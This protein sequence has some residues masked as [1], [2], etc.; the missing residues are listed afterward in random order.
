MNLQKWTQLSEMAAAL[1]VVVT[2]VILIQEVRTNTLAIRQQGLDQR[3]TN[4]AQ[5]FLDPAVL[6]RLYA[7][8]KSVDGGVDPDVAAFMARYDMSMEEALQWTRHLSMLWRGVESEF[9]ING[10]SPTL[11]LWIRQAF[12]SPDI[13]LA[14]SSWEDWPGLFDPAFVQYVRQASGR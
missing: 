5:P 6:P 9:L 7:K 10:R 1:A 8:V 4:V 14:W 13:G 11:D 3:A 2:L 12:R